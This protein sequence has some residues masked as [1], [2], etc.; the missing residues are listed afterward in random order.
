MPAAPAALSGPPLAVA[1]EQFVAELP[2]IDRVLRFRFRRRPGPRRAEAVADARA[3]AWH[4]WVGLVRRGR[5]PRAV[6]PTGI[7]ANAARCALRGRQLG[8]GAGGRAAQ[9]VLH[10]GAPR[11]YRYSVVS[12]D[13]PEGGGPDATAAWRAALAVD[14]RASPADVACLRIDLGAWLDGLPR[15]QRWLAERLAAGDRVGELAG[16]LGVTPGAVSQTRARLAASWARFQAQAAA[17]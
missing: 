5:D 7:A 6:G 10:P 1:Q 15:R 3:A 4:A 9:D 11:R 2:R 8:C 13:R 14:R 16:R 12:L 17:L